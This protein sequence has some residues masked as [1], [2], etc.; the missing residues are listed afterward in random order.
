MTGLLSRLD[1]DGITVQQLSS[2]GSDGASVMLGG[3]SGV[4]TRLLRIN[5]FLVAFHCVLHRQQLGCSGAADDIAYLKRTFF[6]ITEQFGRF[7]K[8]SG[9]R[10]AVFKE[11]QERRGLK[12][13]KII[14]STFTRW[15][16][17]DQVTYTLARRFVSVLDTL[18]NLDEERCDATAAGLY[19]KMATIAYVGW[20]LHMRDVLPLLAMLAKL[21][22]R[23]CEPNIS[24]L[25]QLNRENFL[26]E[27][28]CLSS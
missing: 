6:P 28:L 5:P 19:G 15:L 17:H 12:V 1:R 14:Q 20:L 8:D 3:V 16:T 4:A 18:R 26:F 9:V 25:Q 21:F 11:M 7:M 22:Q 13:L 10:V 23:Q 27:T 24:V 2:F